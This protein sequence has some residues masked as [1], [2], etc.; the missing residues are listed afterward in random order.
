[1]LQPECDPTSLRVF[2]L[3]PAILIWSPALIK[4]AAK[5][6]QNAIFLLQASPEATPTIFCSAIKHYIKLYGCLL[7]RVI[8]NVLFLVSPSKPTT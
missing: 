3:I 6:E 5:V 8:A 7:K 2:P 1:M 4:N